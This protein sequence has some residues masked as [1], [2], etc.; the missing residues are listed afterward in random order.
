MPN[1]GSPSVQ[2]VTLP[3]DDAAMQA[4]SSMR[5][6]IADELG[7]PPL[8]PFGGVVRVW[9]LLAA[10]NREVA[11]GSEL[12]AEARSAWDAVAGFQE[13]AD[14]LELHTFHGPR[15]A[16][17]GWAALT[18]GNVVMTCSRWYETAPISLEVGATAVE[19]LSVARTHGA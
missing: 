19:L 9:R 3:C 5:N 1:R 8:V 13:L 17:H 18:A 15:A 10:N 11:R 4:W 14:R 2:V 12:F 16:T 6:H 7:V